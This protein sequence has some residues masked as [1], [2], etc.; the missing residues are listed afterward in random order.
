MKITQVVVALYL[1][2]GMQALAT[3]HADVLFSGASRAPAERRAGC[4][5]IWDFPA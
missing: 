2:V 3:V 5:D 1:R 4:H